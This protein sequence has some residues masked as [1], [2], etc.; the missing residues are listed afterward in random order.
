MNNDL[1][2]NE[3]KIGDKHSKNNSA[4]HD[5]A[6]KIIFY[7]FSFMLL[8]VNIAYIYPKNNVVYYQ[9]LYL[10]NMCL[11]LNFSLLSKKIKRNMSDEYDFEI[12]VGYMAVSIMLLMV[13]MAYHKD[14]LLMM[15]CFF[16]L[17]SYVL[18]VNNK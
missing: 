10:I 7:A 14:Y 13:A 2:A 11:Y 15:A 16:V 1:M 18:F 12:I 4:F 5:Q 3:Q 17:E 6:F 9:L 8:L